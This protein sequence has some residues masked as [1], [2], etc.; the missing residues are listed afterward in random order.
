M[1]TIFELIEGLDDKT[2]AA[3]YHRDYLTT[4]D[5]KYRKYDPKKYRKNKRRRKMHVAEQH[6]LVNNQ[7]ADDL[8]STGEYDDDNQ[9]DNNQHDNQIDEVV[10]VA[11]VIK[12]LESVDN[13]DSTEVVQDLAI[14]TML[15]ELD[16]Q[17]DSVWQDGGKAFAEYKFDSSK[18]RETAEQ[19]N[20]MFGVHKSLDVQNNIVTAI[21][22]DR[23]SNREI[24]LV[25]DKNAKTLIATVELFFFHA[26]DS[27]EQSAEL[28]SFELDDDS[29]SIKE[30]ISADVTPTLTFQPANDQ[31]TIQ[32]VIRLRTRVVSA[33][34]SNDRLYNEFKSQHSPDRAAE[35]LIPII[36]RYKA[37]D[38]SDDIVKQVAA[39]I[40]RTYFR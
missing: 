16:Y 33:L 10:S 38:D 5:A 26:D 35:Y 29:S 30:A 4:R 23:I 31:D 13:R 3:V 40:A 22:S 14:L 25:L 28:D 39:D 8:N 19:F 7:L 1:P 21:Y 24:S 17:E 37:Q 2:A 27:T 12:E 34:N 6:D 9:I 32:T 36:K 18:A 11:D 20:N 15:S